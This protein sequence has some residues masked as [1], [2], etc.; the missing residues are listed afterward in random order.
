MFWC[1]DCWH[2]RTEANYVVDGFS[3]CIKHAVIRRNLARDEIDD[4]S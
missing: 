1:F 4:D 2:V 3:V